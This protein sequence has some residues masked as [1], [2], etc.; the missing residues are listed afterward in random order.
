[1]MV[2]YTV[3]VTSPMTEADR[4]VRLHLLSSANVKPV[5]SVFQFTAASGAA[6]VSGRIRLA[7][8]QKVVAVAELSGRRFLLAEKMVEVTV[9][10]CG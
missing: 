3:S 1:M 10:S 8:T 5:L 6:N 9:G 4:V 2:A 7:K